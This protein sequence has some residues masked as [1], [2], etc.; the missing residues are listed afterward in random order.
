MLTVLLNLNK[1]MVLLWKYLVGV[2][3]LYL[4]LTIDDAIRLL[5]LQNS[6]ETGGS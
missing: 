3:K 5:A 6:V 2:G 1:I 4:L